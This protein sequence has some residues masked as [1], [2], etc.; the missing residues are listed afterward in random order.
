[1]ANYKR[2]TGYDCVVL[3]LHSSRPSQLGY[4]LSVAP[5]LLLVKYRQAFLFTSLFA[6][7]FIALDLELPNFQATLASLHH[8]NKKQNEEK[9]TSIWKNRSILRK[10]TKKLTEA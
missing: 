1:M 3:L 8:K 2:E 5:Q 9:Y 6:D 10:E 7:T 4:L